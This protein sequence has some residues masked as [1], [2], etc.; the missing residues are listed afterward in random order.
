MA[1]E[2]VYKVVKAIY[3]NKPDLVASFPALGSFS[4]QRMAIP[5]Q[6]MD[7]HPGAL[8]FYKEVGLLKR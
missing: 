8:K 7:F 4:P 1:D 2:V 6:G 5:I 3:E